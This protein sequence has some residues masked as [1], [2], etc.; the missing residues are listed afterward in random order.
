[1]MPPSVSPRS[2]VTVFLC[3]SVADS[4][5]VVP[6]SLR[7]LRFGH[8]VL[9]RV[10]LAGLVW[11]ARLGIPGDDEDDG[12]GCPARPVRHNARER[13]LDLGILLDHLGFRLAAD[14][15]PIHAC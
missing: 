6:H 12:T 15:R 13:P 8:L 5:S 11:R 1:M 4:H 14:I 2:L 9:L 7:R 10:G 3:S